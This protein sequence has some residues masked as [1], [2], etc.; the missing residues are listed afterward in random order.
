MLSLIEIERPSRRD[1]LS[2]L[3]AP[4]CALLEGW[5]DADSWT[6]CL[7]WPREVRALPWDRALNWKSL[8]ASLEHAATAADPL[9]TCPFLGGWI[10]F[11]C[12]ETTALG[13]AAP[14]PRTLPPEPAAFFAR[15]EAGIAIDPGGHAYLFA[16]PDDEDRYREACSRLAAVSHGSPEPNVPPVRDSLGLGAY[17]RAVGSI[18][19]A[20]RDGDVYQVNLTRSF[21]ID[22]EVSPSELY[23][24]LVG[25]KPP[26][27]SAFIRGEDWTIVSAS[28]EVLLSFDRH[29]GV[30]ESRPIKGTVRRAGDDAAEIRALLE[31]SK[32]AAEHL[33]IV[34][35][36]RN[37]LGKVAPP[38]CVSVSAYRTVRTLAH[39]HHLESTVRAE[40]LEDR[41]VA[42]ILEALSPAGSI[43]GAPKRAAVGMI[44]SIEPVPRGI[45]TG[46]IGFIDDRGRSE[47]SVA[48]RTA[49]VTKQSARYHAGGGIVWDSEADAEDAESRAK[50]IAFLRFFGQE[51]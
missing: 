29:A 37:D 20:I 28:P 9:P 6:I 41:G 8:V 16:A 15:H 12:Y 17:R 32:D 35:L 33:M 42:D 27:T 40:G 34:D 45:Y 10:G 38:G 2:A 47:F 19:D 26:R 1:L 3:S 43:T 14:M 25:D 51:C 22:E 7:P 48:I 39:V 21:E 23:L 5:S 13:E 50:S 44:A 31:S 46:S 36:V 18:R 24:A 11:L 49:V 4:G 30:A